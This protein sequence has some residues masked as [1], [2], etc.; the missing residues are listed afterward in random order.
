[1]LTLFGDGRPAIHLDELVAA[2][3]G[4]AG[5]VADTPGGPILT[6]LRPG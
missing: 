6:G 5:V 2:L 3:I 1:M 4:R